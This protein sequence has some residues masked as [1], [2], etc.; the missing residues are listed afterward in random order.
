[1]DAVSFG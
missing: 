1:M